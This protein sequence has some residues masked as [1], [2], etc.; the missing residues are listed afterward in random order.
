MNAF[1]TKRTP[2]TIASPAK[3]LVL[4]FLVPF[5]KR[6][7]SSRDSPSKMGKVFGQ[8]R[9]FA[10]MISPESGSRTLRMSRRVTGTQFFGNGV[11]FGTLLARTTLPLRKLTLIARAFLPLR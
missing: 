2:Q 7:M 3:P 8:T 11:R 5:G 1:G 6:S 9:D 10:G 4:K